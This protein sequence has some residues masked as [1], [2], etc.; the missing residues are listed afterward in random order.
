[1]N[2]NLVIIGVIAVL[3]IGGYFAYQ[4]INKP[5]A[6]VS[7]NQQKQQPSGETKT[8]DNQDQTNPIVVGVDVNVGQTHEIIYTDAGYSP[9]M[10]TIKVGD[11]VTWKN[12]SSAGDWVGSAMHPTHTV[13][14]GTT[15]QQ[16][17]PDTSNTSFDECKADKSGESW[18]FTF[19]KAGAWGYHNHVNAKHFG[20]VTVE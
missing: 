1:M 5:V 7:D 3:L 13:Y 18:S 19:T 15:L 10:L 9:S 11:T 12:Q 6:T 16:H 2:K 20:K 4:A 8:N 14:S 17:C